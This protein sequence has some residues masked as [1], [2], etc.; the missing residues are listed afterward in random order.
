MIDINFD[1]NNFEKSYEEEINRVNEQLEKEIVFA[2]I[3]DVNAGKSSTI[4]RIIGEEVAPV[5]AEPGETVVVE[6]YKYKDKII[7]ADT[8][9]L[10]DINNKNSEETIK[11]FKEADVILF[12]LN[13]AGTVFSEGEKKHFDNISKINKRLIFVLNKIDAAENIP[14]LVKYVQ[15]KTN[16]SF[17]VIPISSRT[18][19]NI[20]M[21]RNA[22]LD[23]LEEENKDILFA[24]QLK[25]K[26][27]TANKWI[28]AAV[29][30]AAYRESRLPGSDNIPLTVTGIQVSLM[31]KLATL[32]EKPL[33]KDRAKELVIATLAG[34]LGK[35]LFRKAVKLIPG[36]GSI[37]SAG[38]A[39]GMTLGLGYAIKYAYEN[40][41]ELDAD[42]LNSLSK[43]FMEEK[44]TL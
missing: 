19:D 20:D 26:S 42:L 24:R 23:I 38:I 14:S 18:G 34:K 17:K 11:F 16:Y 2:M 40:N 21:L 10:D 43:T 3:G 30:A 22:I 37:A 27:S 6:K 5:G 1:E 15:D 25:E 31:V 41:I 4:N 32:Y 7:F 13:A 36:A 29:S 28:L 44:A 8:P 35:S 33:T 12:F 9:G 39:G